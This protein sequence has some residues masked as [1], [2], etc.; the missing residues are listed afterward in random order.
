MLAFQGEYPDVDTVP[1][2]WHRESKTDMPPETEQQ[3]LG[4][5]QPHVDHPQRTMVSRL[6]A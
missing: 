5:I 6:R 2:A 1:K 4:Q 3:G